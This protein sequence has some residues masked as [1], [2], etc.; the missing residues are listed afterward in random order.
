MDV[1]SRWGELRTASPVAGEVHLDSRAKYYPLMQERF[2]GAAE[3]P[4]LSAAS[5]EEVLPGDGA[6]CVAA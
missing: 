3:S 6:A 2:K 5:A 4:P 1:A